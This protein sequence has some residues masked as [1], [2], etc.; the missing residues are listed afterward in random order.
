MP[1]LD[2]GITMVRTK[3]SGE[4]ESHSSNILLEGDK[5]Q[6]CQLGNK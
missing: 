6:L 5:Q 4:A 2:T 1:V 3:K